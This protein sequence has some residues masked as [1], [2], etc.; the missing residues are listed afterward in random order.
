M[1]GRVAGPEPRVAGKACEHG[2]DQPLVAGFL[3]V[4]G[5][6]KGED[7]LPGTADLLLVSPES[8]YGG[9]RGFAEGEG[10]HI[11]RYRRSRCRVMSRR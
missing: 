8:F 4:L 3:E 2:E 7:V 11:L 9:G 1:Q 10:A 5:V 6:Q